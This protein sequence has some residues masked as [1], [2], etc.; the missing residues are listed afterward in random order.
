MP[1]PDALTCLRANPWPG[2]VREL[3]NVIRESLLLARDSPITREIVERVLTHKTARRPPSDQTVAGQIAE[4]LARAKRGEQEDILATLTEIVERELY[5][6]ALPL[7]G[8]DQSKAARWLGVS[9]PTM[10]EKLVKYA[11]HPSQK[12]D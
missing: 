7:A 1:E 3:R 4:L 6:Q 12:D 9:R 10:K 8:G 2:N 5:G 11:L